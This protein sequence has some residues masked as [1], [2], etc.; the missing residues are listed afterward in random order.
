[1]ISPKHQ[2]DIKTAF[3][4]K[5]NSSFASLLPYG[6]QRTVVKGTFIVEKD[7]LC[8]K[9]FLVQDGVFRTFRESDQLEYTTGFSFKGD[10]D[11]SP[12]MSYLQPKL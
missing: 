12:I 6:K 3:S 2:I 8:T 7:E 5:I 9:I 11:T 1:M 10:F 4:E